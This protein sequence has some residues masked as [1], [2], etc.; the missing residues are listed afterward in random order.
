[1]NIGTFQKN[2]HI[3]INVAVVA[4]RLRLHCVIETLV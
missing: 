2:K 3:I 1:M 4:Q